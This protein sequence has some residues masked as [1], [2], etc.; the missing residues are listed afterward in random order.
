MVI[1]E[2]RIAENTQKA[3]FQG[4]CVFCR[5]EFGG[6]A[7]RKHGRTMLNGE[8][9]AARMCGRDSKSSFQI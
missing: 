8:A 5:R 4:V 9:S 1:K 7:T 3:L 6:R 2:A